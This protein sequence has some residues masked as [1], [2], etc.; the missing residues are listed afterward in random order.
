M[1]CIAD[2]YLKLLKPCGNV[3]KHKLILM[4]VS[5]TTMVIVSIVSHK[6]HEDILV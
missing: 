1:V 4:Q 6:H 3:M 5:A 2:C